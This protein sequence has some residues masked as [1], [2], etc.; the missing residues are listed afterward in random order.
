MQRSNS[1]IVLQELP[2]T[3]L[4]VFD[5]SPK[6]SLQSHEKVWLPEDSFKSRFLKQAC[7]SMDYFYFDK[8][9]IAN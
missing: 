7:F 8:L 2:N 4:F 9:I 1:A 3:C 5:V 6:K